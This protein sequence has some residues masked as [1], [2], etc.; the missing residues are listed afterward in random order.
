MAEMGCMSPQMTYLAKSQDVI[1]WKNFM[2]G[3]ISRHVFDMQHEYVP[4]HRKPQDGCGTMDQAI[5][6]QTTAHHPQPM[7]LQELYPP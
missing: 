1:G 4:D 6:Q 2:E 7:D 5:N 3:R